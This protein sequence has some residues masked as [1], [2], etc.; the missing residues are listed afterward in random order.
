MKDYDNLPKDPEKVCFADNDKRIVIHYRVEMVIIN[1]SDNTRQT[2]PITDM[3]QTCLCGP[4][5]S[6][7]GTF[8]VRDCIFYNVI[9]GKLKEK[10]SFDTE[11]TN[12]FDIRSLVSGKHIESK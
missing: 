12:L 1:I 7:F 2:V 9:D 5:K 8:V 10:I 3:C 4:H 6:L 11:N